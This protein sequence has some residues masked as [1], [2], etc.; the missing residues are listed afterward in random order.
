MKK[1][2][3]LRLR[4]TLLCAAL[5][6]LCCLLLT[7]TNNLSAIQMADAMQAVPVLPAQDAAAGTT[8]SLPM[9]ELEA[10]ETVRQARGI[11]H[12][13]SLLAMAA[14]LAAGLF[15]IY[16][17]VGKA[18]DPLDELARQIRGRTAEDLGRPLAVP[19]SGDEA[20]ELARAFNQMSRRLNQVFVMQKN[21][22]HNAAHEFRTPLA[23]LKTRIGLFQK[24]RDF[25]PEATRDFLQIME[26]EVD[27]L[28]ALVESLLELTNLEAAERTAQVSMDALIRDAAGDAALSAA[29]RD[30]SIQTDISPCVLP[31]NERLLHRAVFNLLENAVKYS[32]AGGSRFILEL[33]CALKPAA[34]TAPD[35]PKL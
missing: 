15:L 22:S 11:F 14:V 25:G 4:L 28:S 2:M 10:S 34:C 16:R 32:P 23:I 5:L 3:S 17:L 1:P 8:A 26:G 35:R 13:Q 24:K 20:A 31:G 7:L 27:R 19:D 29:A 33:P 21:F 6:T 12:L 18:L 30:V 9:M